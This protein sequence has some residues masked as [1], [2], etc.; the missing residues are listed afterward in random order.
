MQIDK[1]DRNDAAGIA[2][3]MQTGWYREVRVK[4]L[5]SHAIRHWPYGRMAGA[6]TRHCGSGQLAGGIAAHRL[7][8]IDRGS[9]RDPLGDSE[10]E[11]EAATAPDVRNSDIRFQHPGNA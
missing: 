10:G 3:I 11:I 4:R 9:R 6:A 5:E 1:N 8:S 2:R 7:L